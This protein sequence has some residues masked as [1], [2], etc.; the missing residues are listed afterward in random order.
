MSIKEFEIFHGSVL[1]KMTR[2]KRPLTLRLIETREESWAVYTLNDSIEL[3]VKYS[4]SPRPLA[5]DKGGYSW[6]FTF[7]PEHIAQLRELKKKRP[8]GLAL[9][10]GRKSMKEGRWET[11]LIKP[12]ELSDVINLDTNIQKSITVRYNAGAKKLRI[13]LDRQEKLLVNL[14]ALDS[15]EIP[16]S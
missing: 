1:A 15:W 9:V 13:F 11:C 14:N 8:I 2:N 7:T 4:T 10:C 16:G 12:E 3:F 5:R 6:T